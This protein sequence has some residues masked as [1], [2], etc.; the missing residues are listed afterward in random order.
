MIQS[1]AVVPPDVA[2]SSFGAL[3]A[4]VLI[5]AA[6]AIAV[7]FAGLLIGIA[8]EWRDAA[9]RRRLRRVAPIAAAVGPR[10]P[11]RDAA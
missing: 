7:A 3:L 8:S 9:S 11:V 10:R 6:S 5:V 1:L 2:L 4:P